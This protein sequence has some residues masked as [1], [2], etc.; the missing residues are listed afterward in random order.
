MK[1]ILKTLV[2]VYLHDALI[3]LSTFPSSL[4]DPLFILSIVSVQ[5]FRAG[6]SLHIFDQKSHICLFFILNFLMSSLSSIA[7]C[8]V[9][10]FNPHVL[11]LSES[12]NQLYKVRQSC[13]TY[14]YIVQDR[15]AE[16]NN[17]LRI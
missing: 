8:M 13:Q 15:T 16:P 11:Y 6:K 1:V 7:I 17:S 14:K 12:F 10:L 4:V 5:Y 3:Y 9:P 2:F